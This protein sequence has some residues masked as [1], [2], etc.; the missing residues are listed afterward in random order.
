MN[1]ELNKQLRNISIPDILCE[2]SESKKFNI[3]VLVSEMPVLVYRYSELNCNTCYEIE[4]ASLQEMFLNEYR[5]KVAILCSYQIRKYFTIFKKMNQIKLPIYRI[6]QEAF[7]WKIEDYGN[8]Y[9]FVLHP[10]MTVSDFYIPDKIYPEL[11]KEYL[12]RIKAILI[13]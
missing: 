8:P 11:N 13:N 6:P 12:E 4:L 9:Y 2:D 10:D 5:D 1:L 3:S 7:N